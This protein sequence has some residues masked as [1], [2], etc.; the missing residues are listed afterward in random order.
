MNRIKGIL[1]LQRTV[2]FLEFNNKWKHLQQPSY[3]ILG[4]CEKDNGF[5]S[6]MQ[7]QWLQQSV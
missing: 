2:Y 6:S 5:R 7:P 3:I 1:K 4:F